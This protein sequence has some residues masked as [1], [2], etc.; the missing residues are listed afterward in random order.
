MSVRCDRNLSGCHEFYPRNRQDESARYLLAFRNGR[1]GA[2]QKA[3]QN[4]ELPRLRKTLITTARRGRPAIFVRA[5][6]GNGLSLRSRV[7][8]ALHAIKDL[9][10][11]R[12]DRLAVVRVVFG[13][14]DNN[15]FLAFGRFDVGCVVS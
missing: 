12:R 2:K 14:D 8:R 11:N 1:H 4:R 15:E 13:K 6:F 9:P 7:S 3:L 5:V 10:D